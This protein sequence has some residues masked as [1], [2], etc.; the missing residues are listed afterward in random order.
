MEQVKNKKHQPVLSSGRLR[1]MASS[2][3][4]RIRFSNPL[5]LIAHFE[6]VK[7]A[8]GKSGEGALSWNR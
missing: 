5:F 7:P 4:P 2:A 1:A 8:G 6:R 3:A